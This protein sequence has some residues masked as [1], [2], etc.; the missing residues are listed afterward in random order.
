MSNQRQL[1]WMNMIY[2][3]EILPRLY[4]FIC[5]HFFTAISQ[6]TTGINPAANC[7]IKHSYAKLITNLINYNGFKV[8]F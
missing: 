4:S 7:F 5:G 2:F 8:N 3:V 6:F 1:F